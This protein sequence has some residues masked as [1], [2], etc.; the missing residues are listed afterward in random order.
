MS[1]H[2]VD[3]PLKG[4]LIR[5]KRKLGYYHFGIAINEDRVVHFSAIDKDISDKKNMM[6]VE[7]SLEEF[8][9]GDELEV[10]QPYSSPFSRDEVAKRAKKHIKLHQFRRK[11]YHFVDNNC[12]HFARYCY[13]DKVESKQVVAATVTG[14]IAGMMLAGIAAGAITKKAKQRS[15]NVTAERKRIKNSA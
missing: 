11:Y 9:K 15:T 1:F 12:E 14:V 10:E 4:D 6:I 7:T 13:Y 8:L 3:R 2:K 5:V